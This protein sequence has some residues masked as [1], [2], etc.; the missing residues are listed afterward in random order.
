VIWFCYLL[1]CADGTLYCG[2]TNDLDKRV[3]THNTGKAAK[4]TRVR[5]PV[6]LVYTEECESRS[7]A[8]KRELQIK[9]LSRQAKLNLIAAWESQRGI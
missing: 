8:L 4:Y 3:Q 7:V 6:I 9:A 5:L 2:M 1:R